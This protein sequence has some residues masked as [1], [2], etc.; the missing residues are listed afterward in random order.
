LDKVASDSR[1]WIEQYQADLGNSSVIDGVQESVLMYSL[2]SAYRLT[3]DESYLSAFR[4]GV[5]YFKPVLLTAQ[6]PRGELVYFP[7]NN[8][9]QANAMA[10]YALGWLE[11][12]SAGVKLSSSEQQVLTGMIEYIAAS[13]EDT[14]VFD[15]YYL[16][17]KE[18]GCREMDYNSGWSL[19]VLAEAYRATKDVYYIEKA[20]Q[21]ADYLFVTYPTGDGPKDRDFYIG[22]ARA[23]RALFELT[24]EDRY[25]LL[26]VT[27][28]QDLANGHQYYAAFGEEIAENGLL[29]NN[30]FLGLLDVFDYFQTTDPSAAED[31]RQAII[32]QFP[33]V[34]LT[35]SDQDDPQ[36][37]IITA[38]CSSDACIV[39]QDASMVSMYFKAAIQF[40]RSLSADEQLQPAVVGL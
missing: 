24:G 15:N 3:G 35:K 21:A 8:V 2:A 34:V 14:G 25:Q 1:E 23:L 12:S 11:L 19:A 5:A 40:Q 9:V 17:S 33:K 39:V 32:R 18:I 30:F 38:S 37:F 16:E 22:G 20:D 28:T 7:V 29:Y 26:L 13:V 10:L 31:Y 6:S 27:L 4:Q 36:K